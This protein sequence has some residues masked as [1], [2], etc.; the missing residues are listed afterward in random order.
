MEE[1]ILV[2][3]ANGQ[4]G[5]ALVNALRGKYG[6]NR[7]LA[8]DIQS[9]SSCKY[10]EYFLCLDVLNKTLMEEIIKEKKITQ[11]YLLAAM[12]SASGEQKPLAAWY[13]NMQGLLSILQL[14]VMYQFKVFWP[15][16][17]AVF[18][19]ASPKTD[20]G[21]EA[22]TDPQTV[23][24]MSKVAGE[25]W[26]RYYYEK[27]GVDVRSLRYPGLIGY[28]AEPGGGTTDY[29]VSIFHEAVQKGSYTCFLNEDSYLPMMYMPDAIRATMEIMQAP[30]EK[31]SVRTSY[32]VAAISF[33]PADV[34]A[35][36][37]K[38]FPEFQIKY[39]PDYRQEIANS[40]P[41]S[42]EDGA[43]RNDWGWQPDYDLEKMTEDMLEHLVEE[44]LNL[45]F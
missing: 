40:W 42:I 28:D 31:I 34:Y 8:A 37:Q 7:V 44:E 19:V 45:L 4:V 35:A 16:S 32:N 24:G 39:L 17:I 1:H 21:Q 36:I 11:V 22:I 38:R 2:I 29:A 25:W 5:T 41:H 30:K 23:Y 26:C 13:L 12:L 27:W 6:I 18:G 9:P 43:A 14:A 20:C 33:S 10:P 15:S 3:G